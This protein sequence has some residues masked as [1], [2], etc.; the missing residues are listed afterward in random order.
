MYM[1]PALHNLQMGSGRT[2]DLVDGAVRTVQLAVYLN[3]ECTVLVYPSGG[4]DHINDT[5]AS[6]RR[7]Q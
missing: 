3:P 5:D 1:Y 4:R 6:L 7:H 2:A